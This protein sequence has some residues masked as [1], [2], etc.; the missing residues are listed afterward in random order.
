MKT[1]NRSC[2]TIKFSSLSFQK[3]P[4]VVILQV[5]RNVLCETIVLNFIH[6]IFEAATGCDFAQQLV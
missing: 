6:S 5:T 4:E 3:S 1:D 2:P